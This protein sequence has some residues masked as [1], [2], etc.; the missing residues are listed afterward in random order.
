MFPRD[1]SDLE[2]DILYEIFMIAAALD[3]PQAR[4]L[5][6]RSTNSVKI[7]LGWIP[8][9]HVCKAWRYIMIHDMPI[10]WAG[11]PCAIPAA[12]DVVLSRAREAPLVLDTMI[13]HRKYARERK[14]NKKFVLALCTIAIGNIRRAR[15][16]SY[17]AF[18]DDVMLA[19]SWYQAMNDTEM[20]LLV[21]LHL[22]M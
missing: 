3:P 10:L 15:R 20:P 13:E 9:S 14:V 4:M 6:N 5:R 7:H 1:I 19:T 11:I 22:C 21:D 8:L 18:L 12:R 17:D 16:L 2:G